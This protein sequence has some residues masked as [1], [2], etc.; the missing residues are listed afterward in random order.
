MGFT[1]RSGVQ[2]VKVEQQI[3]YQIIPRKIS[4]MKAGTLNEKITSYNLYIFI[5]HLYIA[6][7][8][9]FPKFVF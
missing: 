6:G 5:S 9:L 7:I 8:P 3:L 2:S 4:A 1:G